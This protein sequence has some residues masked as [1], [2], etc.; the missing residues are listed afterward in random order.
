[1]KFWKNKGKA[2]TEPETELKPWPIKKM[3]PLIWATEKI[4]KWPWRILV[5]SCL[6]TVFLAACGT[7]QFHTHKIDL[8]FWVI[9]FLDCFFFTVAE[10][11]MYGLYTDK[12]RFELQAWTNL[13]QDIKQNY[14]ELYHFS[15]TLESLKFFHEAY[16]DG[17]W[18]KHTPPF[19]LFVYI[20][21]AIALPTIWLND[22]LGRW[23]GQFTIAFVIFLLALFNVKVI[24]DL[25]NLIIGYKEMKTLQKKTKSTI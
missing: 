16:R 5:I 10:I 12:Q 23:I 7:I 18:I 2:A 15:Q 6:A 1:M 25:Y 19:A 14:S 9:V 17:L 13:V 24:N 21:Y 11:V 20:V 8:I 4:E 22:D 3:K